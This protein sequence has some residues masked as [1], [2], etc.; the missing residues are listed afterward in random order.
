MTSV[1]KGFREGNKPFAPLVTRARR[2]NSKIGAGAGREQR[3]VA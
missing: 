3:L 2:D 1:E